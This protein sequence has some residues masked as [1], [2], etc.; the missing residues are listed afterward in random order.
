MTPLGTAL[1]MAK[2][3]IEDKDIT[4]GSWYRPLIILV[5]DGQPNDSW[6]QPLDAFIQ[7]GRSKKCDRMAMAIGHDADEAV[8]KRFLEGTSNALFYAHD[9]KD[10][11][12]F[13]KL[14]TMSVTMRT[15][16]KDPNIVPQAEPLDTHNSSNNMLDDFG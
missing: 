1:K 2:D 11:Q 16:A 13:F 7:E 8:L 14:V 4:K 6:E 10:I 3:M 12:K 15:K 9:A 5:S